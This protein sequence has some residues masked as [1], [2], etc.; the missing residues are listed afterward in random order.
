MAGF[1][2][3]RGAGVQYSHTVARIEQSLDENVL[4]A[5]G[6]QELEDGIQRE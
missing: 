1:A 2:P 6:V 4:D 3:G 5:L